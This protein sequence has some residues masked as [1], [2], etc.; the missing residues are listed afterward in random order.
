[1]N[2]ILH[3]PVGEAMHRPYRLYA[4]WACPFCHRVV[5]G[6][7][8]TGLD[9]FVDITWM[10]DTKRERG[11]EIQEGGDPLFSASY[12]SDIYSELFSESDYRPSVPLL[13]RQSNKLVISTDS[14]QTLRSISRGFDGTYLTDIDLAPSAIEAKID[15]LNAWLHQ[16]INRA[17]YQ[18]GFETNQR[19]YEQKARALFSALEA[20]DRR[21][22]QSDFLF[23]EYLT[24]SDLYLYATLARFDDIYL[25]LF[26]CSLRRI[27]DYENLG[28]YKDKLQSRPEIAASYRADLSKRHYYTSLIHTAQ[29]TLDLNP[30]GIVPL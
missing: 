30:S 9:E 2:N 10:K 24:E 1:M 26:R 29:G 6:L 11:W 8:L 5:A 21:L 17:V 22:A 12:L 3:S 19:A 25:P 18:S 15:E 7:L 20:M 4:S 23:G 14:A 27:V 28:R 13:I 16:N